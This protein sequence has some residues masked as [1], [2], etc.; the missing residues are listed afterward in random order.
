[1]ILV[2]FDYSMFDERRGLPLEDLIFLN[3]LIDVKGLITARDTGV[4][5]I[6]RSRDCIFTPEYRL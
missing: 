5:K 6:G 2:A 1:V 4:L 3:Q